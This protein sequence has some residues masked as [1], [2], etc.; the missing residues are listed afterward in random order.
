MSKPEDDADRYPQPI[1]LFEH[2]VIWLD[3]DEELKEEEGKA[4]LMKMREDVENAVRQSEE[5]DVKN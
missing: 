3:L 4:I 2:P 5:E 1:E